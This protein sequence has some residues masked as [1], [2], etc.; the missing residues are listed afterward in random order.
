MAKIRR[1]D[2]VVVIAGRDKGTR[3]KVQRV[4]QD[5]RLIVSGVHM[6]KKHQKPNPQLEIPGGIIEKEAPINRSNVA[7]V[8]PETNKADPVSYTHLT[9]PTIL[10]V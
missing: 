7:I 4:L 3:G 1:D 2:E 10:L 9:L 8:N 5:G 6:V